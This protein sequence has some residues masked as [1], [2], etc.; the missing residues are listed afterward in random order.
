MNNF[1]ESDSKLILFQMKSQ[2]CFICFSFQELKLQ[3]M[4]NVGNNFGFLFVLDLKFFEVFDIYIIL[5]VKH[6]P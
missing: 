1:N 2:S 4:K 6:I 5:F 3:E